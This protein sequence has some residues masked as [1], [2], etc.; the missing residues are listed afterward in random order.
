VRIL[1]P[2]IASWVWSYRALV[3]SV[4]VDTFHR[5]KELKEAGDQGREE[6]KRKGSRDW[7]HEKVSQTR[8]TA[9]NADF[10]NDLLLLVFGFREKIKKSYCR[11]TT[12]LNHHQCHQTDCDHERVSQNHCV[13]Q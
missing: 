4:L 6:E 9:I 11:Y 5:T 3:S 7:D 2:W 8:I 12:H 10:A 13:D 1:K